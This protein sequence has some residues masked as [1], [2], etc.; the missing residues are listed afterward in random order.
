MTGE[1]DQLRIDVTAAGYAAESYSECP[2]VG[3]QIAQ[4]YWHTGYIQRCLDAGLV[5]P[6]T[7]MHILGQIAYLQGAKCSN[8][9]DGE[10]LSGGWMAGWLAQQDRHSL[11]FSIDPNADNILDIVFGRNVLAS[12][13]RS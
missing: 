5:P 13:S 4:S 12:T 2:Y 7:P 11:A 6:D 1:T 8:L 9:P 10:I 3:G